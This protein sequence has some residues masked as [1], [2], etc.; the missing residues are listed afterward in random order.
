MKIYS[1]SYLNTGRPQFTLFSLGAHFQSPAPRPHVHDIQG[2]L[3]AAFMVHRGY[4][5]SSA[6]TSSSPVGRFSYSGQCLFSSMI[7]D[8]SGNRGYCTQPCRRKY[9]IDGAKGHLLSPKDLNISEHIGHLIESGIDSFKIEGRLKH[10]EYV[11]G[12]VRILFLF[13]MA[14]N[15]GFRY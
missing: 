4:M 2:R 13:N 15:N 11:A 9:T 3:P 8:K 5:R 10:P 14:L 1:I 12:V 6:R 7:G